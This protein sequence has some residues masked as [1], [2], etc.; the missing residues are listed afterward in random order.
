VCNLVKTIQR[1]G[2]NK[3]ERNRKITL[4]HDVQITTADSKHILCTKEKNQET[5]TVPSKNFETL[6]FSE[7][8]LSRYNNNNYYLI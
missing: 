2:E 3:D 6:L 8:P 5:S 7:K 4:S 1:V